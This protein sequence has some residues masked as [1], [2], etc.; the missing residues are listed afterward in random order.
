MTTSPTDTPFDANATANS[1]N[2]VY[3]LAQVANIAYEEK[4]KIQPAVAKLGLEDFLKPGSDGLNDHS[5]SRYVA[6]IEKA[7]KS[8]A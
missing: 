8:G 7:L 3:W 4:N 1:L 5:M 6:H 2:N